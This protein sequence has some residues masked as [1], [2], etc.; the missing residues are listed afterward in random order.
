[1]GG[2]GGGG[3]GIPKPERACARRSGSSAVWEPG[4]T[5]KF[6]PSGAGVGDRV[7]PIMTEKGECLPLPMPSTCHWVGGNAD[8][9][10]LPCP[11]AL[12]MGARS[13]VWAPWHL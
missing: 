9:P 12:C 11:W 3:G 6:P 13:A 8:G 4:K 7:V 10:T 1:M 5:Q 2:G